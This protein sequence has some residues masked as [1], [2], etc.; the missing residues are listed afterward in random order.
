[1]KH[2]TKCNAT[3]VVAF[4]LCSKCYQRK[5]YA[6]KRS[7]SDKRVNNTRCF[8]KTPKAG[9]IIRV[10]LEDGEIKHAVAV[11]LIKRKDN[12]QLVKAR[13]VNRN[14]SLNDVDFCFDEKRVKLIK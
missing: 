13:I 3:P 10:Y 7:L 1:M 5:R 6:Q 9:D 8:I 4:G 14:Y 2:C 11:G 12:R